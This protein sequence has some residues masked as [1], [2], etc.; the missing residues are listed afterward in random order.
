MT[1]TVV[2]EIS[3]IEACKAR[4][5]EELDTF[6]RARGYDSILSLCSYATDSDPVFSA[7]GLKGIEVRG[8]LWAALRKV[9][10][11]VF[12]NVRPVPRSYEELRAEP[13]LFPS[14]NWD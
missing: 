13:G 11:E 2:N 9:Q 5:Q 12:A 1:D 7:E 8:K 10:E 14:L 6:A 4:A 3:I